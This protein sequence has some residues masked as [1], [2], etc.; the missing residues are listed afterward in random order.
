MD[1]RDKMTNDL[2]DQVSKQAVIINEKDIQI[3]HLETV[4][5]DLQKKQTG[6]DAIREALDGERSLVILLNK[7]IDSYKGRVQALTALNDELTHLNLILQKKALKTGQVSP[8]MTKAW[9]IPEIDHNPNIAE[10]GDSGTV[11]DQGADELNK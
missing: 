8:E 6:V 3:K 1:S 10:R 9:P 7:Q 11:T 5:A 2:T 4:C